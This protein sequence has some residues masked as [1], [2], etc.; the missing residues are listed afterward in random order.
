MSNNMFDKPASVNASEALIATRKLC[1]ALNNS[2]GLLNEYV[3]SCETNQRPTI[4]SS[5]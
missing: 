2:L 4:G 3:T 1:L 5:S